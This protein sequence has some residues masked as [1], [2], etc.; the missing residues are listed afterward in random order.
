MTPFAQPAT[1]GAVVSE[2]PVDR[3]MSSLLRLVTA[4][5]LLAAVLFAAAVVGC[6]DRGPPSSDELADLSGEDVLGLLGDEHDGGGR[7]ICGVESRP[8]ATVAPS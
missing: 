2:E 5:R 6:A 7:E 3:T 8:W 4:R 1:A